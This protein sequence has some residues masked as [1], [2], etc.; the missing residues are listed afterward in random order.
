MWLNIYPEMHG[1]VPVQIV[2]LPLNPSL[3]TQLKE[4]LIFLQVAFSWH[5]LK[6]ATHSSISIT[7]ITID[8]NSVVL[9]KTVGAW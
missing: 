3:Q 6:S 9:R 5:E 7:I 8:Y 1:M 2:P 4:P